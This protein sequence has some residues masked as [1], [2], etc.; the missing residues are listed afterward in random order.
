[1]IRTG[2]WTSSELSAKRLEWHIWIEKYLNMFM[3]EVTC[4]V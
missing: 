4:N 3:D 1:M 2:E